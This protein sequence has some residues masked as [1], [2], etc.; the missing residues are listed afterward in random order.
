MAFRIAGPAG[1]PA[2]ATLVVVIVFRVTAAATALVP[3]VIIII[4]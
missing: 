3:A 1:M 4:A 2:S